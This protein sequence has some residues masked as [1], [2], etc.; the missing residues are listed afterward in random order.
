[1]DRT[2]V[3]ETGL[4]ITQDQVLYQVLQVWAEDLKAP[5]LWRN[6]WLSVEQYDTISELVYFSS[7]SFFFKKQTK[8]KS[9]LSKLH[10]KAC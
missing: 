5:F 6:M 7:F 3:E 2:L 9:T 8:K 1:M 10:L 4:V